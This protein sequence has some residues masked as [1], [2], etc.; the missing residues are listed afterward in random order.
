VAQALGRR[1]RIIRIDSG[2]ESEHAIPSRS[3]NFDQIDGLPEHYY[4]QARTAQRDRAARRARRELLQRDQRA[5]GMIIS[6]AFALLHFQ[7]QPAKPR[8]AIRR[9]MRRS[10]SSVGLPSR[11]ILVTGT[12]REEGSGTTDPH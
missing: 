11:A 10:P 5:A 6:G 9:L 12:R 1:A 7:G 2:E 3:F 4:R 8:V